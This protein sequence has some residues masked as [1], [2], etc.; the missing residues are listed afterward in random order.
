[1]MPIALAVAKQTSSVQT[2]FLEARRDALQKT[3]AAECIHDTAGDNSALGPGKARLEQV[4][5]S[6]ITRTT[7]PSIAYFWATA[8]VCFICCC[9]IA[10]LEMEQFEHVW[11][12][13]GAWTVAW[14]VPIC[15]TLFHAPLLSQLELK[16]QRLRLIGSTRSRGRNV[17]S[18][19]VHTGG[20]ARGGARDRSIGL[21]PATG[22]DVPATG[23]AASGLT[24]NR[25]H[26]L[27]RVR[28]TG[29]TRRTRPN[30][31]RLEPSSA[32][33]LKAGMVAKAESHPN[34]SM[35]KL[36]SPQK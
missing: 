36:R 7:V 33:N 6:R 23:T 24:A 16:E 5:K 19:T 11:T 21:G 9:A 31:S 8:L 12:A 35:Y 1:M 34:A 18:R 29:G 27:A 20:G 2:P 10:V 15:V 13:P 22:S 4:V 14:T 32:R 3:P 30:P 28:K 17:R 26:G 25:R